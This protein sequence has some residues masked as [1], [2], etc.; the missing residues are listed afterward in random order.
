LLTFASPDVAPFRQA[1]L[2]TMM[3]LSAGIPHLVIASSHLNQG[4]MIEAAPTQ[5][6]NREFPQS[7]EGL[8]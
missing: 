7:N 1:V 2:H 3:K 4:G 5:F 6:A 8:P